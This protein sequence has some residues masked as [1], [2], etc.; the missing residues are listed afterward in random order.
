MP[1]D[2]WTPGKGRGVLGFFPLKFFWANP[3]KCLSH[4]YRSC[5]GTRTRGRA[6]RFFHPNHQPR[7]L[8]ALTNIFS[9]TVHRCAESVHDPHISNAIADRNLTIFDRANLLQMRQPR[10]TAPVLSLLSTSGAKQSHRMR[11]EPT[12]KASTAPKMHFSPNPRALLLT[13]QSH[14]ASSSRISHSIHSQPPLLNTLPPRQYH[15][16]KP[17]PFRGP[18]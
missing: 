1:D 12:K 5:E 3:N 9:P 13:K 4:T 14:D 6:M 16:T 7:P 8:R 17:S 15:L 10:R 2:F 11:N 18:L